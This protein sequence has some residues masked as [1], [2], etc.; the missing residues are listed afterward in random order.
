M[1]IYAAARRLIAS[2]H[3]WCRGAFAR[4]AQ[5]GW[6]H[7]LDA[8]AVQFDLLGALQRVHGQSIYGTP[9]H[10]RMEAQ[11]WKM[12]GTRALASLNDERGHAA[13]LALLDELA[14][15]DG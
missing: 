3:S 15:L 14:A 1:R 6:C 9:I 5:G 10:L 11:A 12:F 7:Y 13:V 8:E 2:E 4:D